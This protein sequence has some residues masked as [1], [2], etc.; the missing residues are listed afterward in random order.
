MF[1]FK[2]PLIGSNSVKILARWAAELRTY[3]FLD[4]KDYELFDFS[5]TLTAGMMTFTDHIVYR[6]KWFAIP[7]TMIVGVMVNVQA[8]AGGVATSEIAFD[9]PVPSRDTD[10]GANQVISNPVLDNG[11]VVTG[12]TVIISGQSIARYYRYDSANYTL[13]TVGVF[14]SFFYEIG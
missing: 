5:P 1:S 4:S 3:K 12:N 11:A 13:G 10:N 14:G 6:A 8:T 2:I 9:L 7:G